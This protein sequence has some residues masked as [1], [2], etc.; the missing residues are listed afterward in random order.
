MERRKFIRTAGAITLGLSLA[1]KVALARRREGNPLP[2]WK[3]FNLLDFYS[4]G[5]R[6]NYKPTTVEHF[7]WMRDWGFD[8][9]RIPIA[10][11]YYLKFDRSRDITPE[12]VDQFDPEKLEEIDRLVYL[13][14]GAG[15][16]VSLN[17]H[18]AP[19]YCINS[20]FHE[21]FNLWKDQAAQDAFCSHWKMWAH[22]YRE[23]SREKISFDL[24]NE[25]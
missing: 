17:L 22:R 20:G 21:P 4:P 25:P 5:D 8:F 16:H 1:E 2:R 24:L 9:V 10:Y 23:I 13:A 11:P 12:E 15:M 7:S 6:P 18:R 19:G 3:R 14:Q